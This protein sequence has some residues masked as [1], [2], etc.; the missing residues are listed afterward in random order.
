MQLA[1]RVTLLAHRTL[2]L[3]LALGLSLPLALGYA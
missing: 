2:T 1:S 3:P